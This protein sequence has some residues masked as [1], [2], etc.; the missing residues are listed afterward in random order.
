VVDA[1]CDRA[2]TK[3][4]TRRGMSGITFDTGALV[5]LVDRKHPSMRKV[6][7]AAR[8]LGVPIHVP[9]GVVAEW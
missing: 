5:A 1:A 7:V 2:H 9:A 4:A 6:C 8:E 3:E